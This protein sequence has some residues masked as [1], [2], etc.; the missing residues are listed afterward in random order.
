MVER[1]LKGFEMLIRAQDLRD[2]YRRHTLSFMRYVQLHLRLAYIRDIH[3]A[4]IYAIRP[5][6]PVDN[7]LTNRRALQ[8]RRRRGLAYH[9][10]SWRVL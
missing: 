5:H 1:L 2:D 4:Y 7:D 10:G 9:A 6:A 8:A 3:I